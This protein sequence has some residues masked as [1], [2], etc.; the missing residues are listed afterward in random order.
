MVYTGQHFFS[1]GYREEADR[2]VKRFHYSKR[3]PSNIIV[4]GCANEPGGLFGDR[5]R[6]IAACYFSIPPTRWSEN[7]LE[8]SR[9]VRTEEASISLSWLVSKTVKYIKRNRLSNLLVSFADQTQSHH[10]GIYQACS[11]NYSG[12]RERRMDGLI[13]N[14]TFYPGRSCNSRW[15][16][17][18]PT[19]LKKLHPGLDIKPHYDEGKHLYWKACNKQGKRKARNLG[20]LSLPYIKPDLPEATR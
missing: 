2:L 1:V 9:L 14:G 16:T 19:K 10:G 18:S 20:L 8:L 13:V 3:I 4:C 11:W 15:G 5:G 17:Q 6:T 12:K 7:V